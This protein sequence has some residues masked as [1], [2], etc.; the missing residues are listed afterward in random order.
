MHGL[1][2]G[3]YLLFGGALVHLVVHSVGGSIAYLVDSLV[4]HF[5]G[6]FVYSFFG[7]LFEQVANLGMANHRYGGGHKEY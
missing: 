4:D 1:L 2:S 5:L 7:C 3:L 6:G